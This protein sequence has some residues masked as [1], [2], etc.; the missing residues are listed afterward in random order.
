MKRAREDFKT[1][2]ITKH[3]GFIRGPPLFSRNSEYGKQI[4]RSPELKFGFLMREVLLPLSLQHYF[5]TRK[6][7]IR[8]IVV[9]ELSKLNDP[10]LA[11][12]TTLRLVSYDKELLGVFL[13]VSKLG[14]RPLT[15]AKL[16]LALRA[17]N[18]RRFQR[19]LLL[20]E[21]IADQGWAAGSAIGSLDHEMNRSSKGFVTS[22]FLLAVP[23]RRAGLLPRLVHTLKWY[24]E[25]G[26]VYQERYEYN[27]TT[28]DRMRTLMLCRL[29]CV[30]LMPEGT[31]Q[32]ALEKL[33]DMDALRNWHENALRVNPAMGGV[34]KPDYTGYHHKS[35]YPKD[36]VLPALIAASHVVY[37]L[38]GTR[39][40]LDAASRSNLRNAIH[41]MRILSAEYAM[42]NSVANTDPNVARPELV[43]LIPAFA[44]ATLFEDRSRGVGIP[45]P[46]EMS[47][48]ALESLR[49]F[50]RLYDESD[51]RVRAY[52]LNGNDC[53]WTASNMH[54]PGSLALVFALK[55]LA[56]DFGI[57][58]ERSPAGNW[59]KNFAALAIHRRRDWAVTVKGFNN[60]V[61]GHE[62]SSRG[63][64][65]G[66]YQSYGQLVIANSDRAMEAYDI[67]RGWDWTR[68]PGTT[69]L[70]VPP[71]EL[72]LKRSRFY[73]PEELC[74]AV[75]FQ[76]TSRWRNGAFVMNFKRPDY[77]AFRKA[78]TDS[79]TQF[80]FKKSVFFYDELLVCLGSDVSAKRETPVE[81]E[82][83][84][85][86]NIG[87]IRDKIQSIEGR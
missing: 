32:E 85:F 31:L 62:A 28:A 83:T 12:R 16:R 7:E 36:Y 24:L 20:L 47:A 55:Q 27:G 43:C 41:F 44:H 23:L 29:V 74:G 53:E 73:N 25:F 80:A 54:T 19:V 60:F 72:V 15:R 50:L 59:A 14:V 77:G 3:A 37:L 82:T 86:Q 26:E 11:T 48:K 10:K 56:T 45:T 33:R 34:I 67:D 38:R 58:A 87:V 49:A 65:Y 40:E 13:R 66:L 57:G 52:L 63:N 5:L 42:P 76:G 22:L 81:V 78:K 69:T 79:S 75:S 4:I 61:W 1:L 68:L 51:P 35:F 39:F 46:R 84:L 17:V 8:K 9:E 21:Y 71:R 70:R 6:E 30:L 2:N 64:H 18:R